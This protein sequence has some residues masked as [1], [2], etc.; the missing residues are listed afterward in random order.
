[1]VVPLLEN[2][3]TRI[4]ALVRESARFNRRMDKSSRKPIVEVSQL[5]S[6]QRLKVI[7]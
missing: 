6:T 7:V 3:S 1:M 2:T 5:N 4:G